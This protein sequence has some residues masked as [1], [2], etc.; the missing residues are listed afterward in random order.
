MIK[1]WSTPARSPMSRTVVRSKPR[2][3]SNSRAAWSNRSL[4]RA[5]SLRCAGFAVLIDGNGPSSCGPPPAT[6]P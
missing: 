6:L 2:S 3:A 5:E 1:A 4:L